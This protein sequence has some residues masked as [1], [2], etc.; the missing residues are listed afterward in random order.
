MARDKILWAEIREDFL[1]S[2]VGL[3]DLAKKYGVSYSTL[4]KTAATEKWSKQRAEIENAVISTAKPKKEQNKEEQ[5]SAVPFVPLLSDEEI[6]EAKRARL[7]KFM[8]ITDAMM[9]RI[10]DALMSD[11][12]T[13]PQALKLLASALRDLREMQGLNKSELD[14]EEQKARI[15]KLKSETQIVNPEKDNSVTVSFVDTEGAEE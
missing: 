10:E 9:D 6:I 13:S 11:K 2:G 4:R 5:K 7:D 12:V 3:A 8:E 1:M 14:V 15:A